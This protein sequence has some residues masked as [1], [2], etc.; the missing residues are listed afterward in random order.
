VVSGQS[1]FVFGRWSMISGCWQVYWYRGSYD[2]C[3]L[4]KHSDFL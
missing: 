1:Q 3:S 4:A 2:C